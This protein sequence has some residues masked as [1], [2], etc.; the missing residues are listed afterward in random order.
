MTTNAGDTAHSSAHLEPLALVA[1]VCSLIALAGMLGLGVGVLAVFGVGAGHAALRRIERYDERGAVLA[2][3]ALAI[4][5]A[6]GLWAPGLG[7]LL[8]RRARESVTRA[9][10]SATPTR[11]WC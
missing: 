3:A 9:R 7:A 6:V 2:Y 11:G 4:G 10:P 5:Y 8:R 1:V